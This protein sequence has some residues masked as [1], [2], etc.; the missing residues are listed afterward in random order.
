MGLA[1][2]YL[3]LLSESSLVTGYLHKSLFQE[4]EEQD[5]RRLK[6]GMAVPIHWQNPCSTLSLSLSLPDWDVLSTVLETM[7]LGHRAMVLHD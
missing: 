3:L 7:K 4:T 6:D 1:L 2:R 5:K